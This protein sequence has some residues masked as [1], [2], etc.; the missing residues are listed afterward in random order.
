MKKRLPVQHADEKEFASLFSTM[1]TRHNAWTVWSDFIS[2]YAC[3]ISCSVDPTP[4]RMD[5]R[6]EEVKQCLA[7]YS[8]E[9][10]K[11]MDQLGNLLVQMVQRDRNRDILGEMY[12]A[13]DFGSDFTGQFFTPWQVSAMMS[14][15]TLGEDFSERGFISICDPACGAG[16]MLLSAA[17]EYES[18]N[19]NYQEKALFVGQDIDP[20]VAKMAYIQL[21]LYG[22]AGYIVIGNSLTEP[23]TGMDL[24]PH[25]SR[26]ESIWFTPQ[27][28]APVWTVRRE[29]EKVRLALKQV[30]TLGEEKE[31]C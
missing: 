1:T 20:I 31:V 16:A 23:V 7:K 2:T 3:L 9:E 13:M 18:R 24:F 25:V 12:M 28:F 11:T 22:C 30:E 29:V 10:V 26:L 8:E 6:R 14:K 5:A 17:M 15:M 27:F 19:I 4:E 21:S